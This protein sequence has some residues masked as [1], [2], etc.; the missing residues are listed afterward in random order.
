MRERLARRPAAVFRGAPGFGTPVEGRLLVTSDG[1]SPRYDLDREHGVFSREGHELYGHELRD[2]ILVC[3]RTKGGVA[4]GWAL[5]DLKA[6]G[7][8]PKAMIFDVVNPVFVQGCV[9]ADI[10][11]VAGLQW[12]PSARPRTGQWARLDPAVSELI[13]FDGATAGADASTPHPPAGR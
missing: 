12:E 11:I 10:P 13:V 3:S 1:F 4:A 2:A 9:F 6:R 8:A 5:H 7:L